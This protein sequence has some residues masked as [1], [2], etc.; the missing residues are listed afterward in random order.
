MFFKN[1]I[2]F[3]A[4]GIIFCIF[5]L[6]IFS[7]N[8][9]ANI[10]LFSLVAVIPPYVFIKINKKSSYFIL[11]NKGNH[12]YYLQKTTKSIILFSQ[13]TPTDALKILSDD[14]FIALTNALKKVNPGDKIIVKTHLFTENMLKRWPEHIPRPDKIDSYNPSF[15]ILCTVIFAAFISNLVRSNYYKIRIKSSI[16]KIVCHKW[17]CLTWIKQ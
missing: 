2:T 15:I 12:T 1:F 13:N 16:R 5:F 14:F 10:I 17:Y 8:V 7:Q 9:I 11:V 4:I 6:A 3:Y